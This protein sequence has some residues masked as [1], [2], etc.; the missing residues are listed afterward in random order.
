MPGILNRQ[1]C[2]IMG[3]IAC[4]RHRGASATSNLSFR[5][6]AND[7]RRDCRDHRS[8]PR[9]AEFR[10]SDSIFKER[11][12]SLRAN[13]AR[14]RATRWLAMTPKHTFTTSPRHA[15]EALMNLS[16]LEGVGNAG[17]PWHPQPRVRLA[18]VKSTRVNEYP[19]ITRRSRTQ[20]F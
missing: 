11:R 12:P 5:S 18:L 17:C 9:S 3:W 1:S 16:P 14:I 10:T 2:S 6:R 19:G 7:H 15:P 4:S 13:G 8:R 20:W